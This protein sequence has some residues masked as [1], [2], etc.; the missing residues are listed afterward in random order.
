[1]AA[2]RKKRQILETALHDARE[3]LAS[4]QSM[5]SDAEHLWTEAADPE[6]ADLDEYARAA[7][8]AATEEKMRRK[9]AP[10][11]YAM[12]NWARSEARPIPNS[13][14]RLASLYVP[15]S[16][17]LGYSPGAYF[18]STTDPT[19]GT[20][21]RLFDDD[22]DDDDMSSIDSADDDGGWRSD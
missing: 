17:P 7:T 6:E 18:T 21:A 12:A 5:I 4:L 10:P 22:D 13:A 8:F 11:E 3:E 2:E 20:P 14:N 19:L 16:P 15:G 9:L 1:M